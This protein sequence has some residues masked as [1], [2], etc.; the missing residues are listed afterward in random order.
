MSHDRTAERY[1]LCVRCGLPVSESGR[2]CKDC[3]STLTHSERAIWVTPRVALADGRR[4][5]VA[6]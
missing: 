5:R 3:S 2:L 1:P 4:T 6:S